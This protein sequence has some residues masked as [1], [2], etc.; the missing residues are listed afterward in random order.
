MSALSSASQPPSIASSLFHSAAQPSTFKLSEVISE[1]LDLYELLIKMS[2]V[3][4]V[5]RLD[6]S[7]TMFGSRSEIRQTVSNLLINA[8]DATPP[9]GTMTVRLR[10]SVDW[11]T[12]RRGHRILVADTGCGIDPE[13]RER[14]FEP[15]FTTKGER[16]TG[17]GLWLSMSLI[18]RTGGSLRFRSTSR[19]GRSGTCFSVFLPAQVPAV[20]CFRSAAG[21]GS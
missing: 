8:L 10:E 15:F 13:H 6:S 17:L 19:A 14:V 1:L 20:E 12:G 7:A 3:R 4:L 16:G 9:G 21:Q 2:G 11:G 5:R 18:A